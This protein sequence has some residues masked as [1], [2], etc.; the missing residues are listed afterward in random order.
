MDEEDAILNPSHK[1][2]QAKT[3]VQDDDLH[4]L[5]VEFNLILHIPCK[6]WAYITCKSGDIGFFSRTDIAIYNKFPCQKCENASLCISFIEKTLYLNLIE[7]KN[8]PK[9]LAQKKQI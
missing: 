3:L 4:F 7:K 8:I 5:V 1:F 2:A 6:C 9:I